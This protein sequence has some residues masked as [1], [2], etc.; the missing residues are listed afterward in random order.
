[1]FF[2]FIQYIFYNVHDLA[3]GTSAWRKVRDAPESLPLANFND[4]ER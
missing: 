4:S 2:L 3:L 1:M